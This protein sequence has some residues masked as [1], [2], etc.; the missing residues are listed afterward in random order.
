MI[1]TPEQISATKHE[2]GRLRIV[3]CPGSGK[4][5]TVSR[6]IANLIKKGNNPQSIAAITFTEKAA[7]E[8]KLRIRKI[9]DDEFPQRADFGDMFIGT[10]HSF[11]LEMLREIDPI[12]RTYDILDGARRVAF[13]A[14]GENYYNNIKLVK[15]EKR[16]NL[17]FYSTIKQFITSADIMLT[18]RINIKELTD[19]AFGDVFENY[20]KELNEERYLDFPSIINKLVELLETDE[21]NLNLIEHR[22]KHIIVDEFQDV[23]SLQ[24]RL[25]DILSKKAVSVAVV[26]DDDQAIYNWR[27]T[28]VSQIIN[29]GSKI[30]GKCSDVTLDTNFR[31][32]PE[33]VDLTSS[34]ISFNS[35]RIPKKIKS[36]S[37]NSKKYEEGDIHVEMFRNEDDE[38]DFIINRLKEIKDTDFSGRNNIQFSISWSD[39]AILT[40]TNEWASKIIDRLEREGIPSVASSGENIFKRPEVQFLLDCLSHVFGTERWKNGYSSVIETDELKTTYIKIFPSSRF[41]EAKPSNF[42]RK[43]SLIR[44]D[45]ER[46]EKKGKKDYLPGLGLQEVFHRILQAAGADSFDFGEVYSYNLAALSQAISDYESVWIRLRASEVKYFFNFI[47]AY[48]QDTY[49]DQRHK[50]QGI[51]NAIRIMTIHKAKGLEF[52]AV[53]IPDF[54]EKRKPNEAKTFVDDNLYDHERYRGNEEDERRVFYTALTRSEKYIIITGS[55]NAKEKV[56]PRK[57]HRFINELPKKYISSVPHLSRTKSGFS[58]RLK[59]TG[60]YETSYSELISYIRCPEDFLI[61]NVYGFNAGVPSAFGYGTSVHNILNMIHRQ[62]LRNGKIPDKIEISEITSRMFKL[63][64][65]TEG[66]EKTMMQS[67]EKIIENYVEMHSDDFARILETEKKFEFVIDN[68]LINGQIDLLKKLDTNGSI[69]EVEIID[70]K[71]EKKTGIYSSDY[72]RQLRYYAIACLESL[73]MKPEKAYVH[74]LDLEETHKKPDLVDISK[75]K[76]DE[77]KIE[78]RSV[79]SRITEGN[80]PASPSHDKCVNCDYLRICKYSSK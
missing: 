47:S 54:V 23:D 37:V 64:Y 1:M 80:F 8:L 45:I 40:R 65:A 73:N 43:I 18:E 15:L 78:I 11:C 49:H 51:V 19:K 53:F 25:I 28:D 4:T 6:R 9:L 72:E 59:A 75:S 52:P 57:M 36:Y 10:I 30:N 20:L 71:T 27:G 39:I 46:I 41:R 61:R 77:T 67:A 66:L 76:L 14:K 50:D 7:K 79:V 33:I 5:E 56:R 42:L 68:A 12:Y 22:T 29:F 16:H 48:G 34:F 13:L 55:I 32:T 70:F 58:P 69:K 3:A 2:N 21:K 63:R 31:S 38:M 62:Y 24:G 74:H 26:G 60:E 35:R 17:K 44:E